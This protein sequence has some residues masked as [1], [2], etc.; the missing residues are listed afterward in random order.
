MDSR[1]DENK[2]V[3][4]EDSPLA[5]GSSVVSNNPESVDRLAAMHDDHIMVLLN[6]IE[7]SPYLLARDVTSCQDTLSP[8][9]CKGSNLA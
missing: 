7:S 5:L 1:T 2:I 9:Y 3:F 6:L 4:L 8:N